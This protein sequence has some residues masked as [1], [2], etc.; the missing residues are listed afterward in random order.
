MIRTISIAC[1]L[2]NKTADALNRESGRI[3]TEVMIEHY[4]V[5]R[6]HNLWLSNP[7]MQKYHDRI[8]EA[9]FL[10]AHSIDAAQEAFYKACKTS[11]AN[12]ENGAKYPHKKKPYRTTIWKNT[13]MRKKGNQLLLSLARG[14][15]PITFRLPP[16]L[17]V[18]NGQQFLELRLVYDRAHRKYDWHIVIENGLEP[19]PTPG[20]NVA[21]VDLGEVHPAAITDGRDSLVISC[22]ELRSLN[23]YLNKRLAELKSLQ[24]GKQKHSG[25]WWRIQGRINRFLAQNKQQRRDLEHKISRAVVDW[26]VIHQVGTLAIG[27]VRDVADGKRLNRKSQQKV[28]NWSHGTVRRYIAYKA[29]AEGILVNDCV[30]ESYTTQTCVCCGRR[31]KPIGRIYACACGQTY[32]R[33]VGGAANILSRF[34][35]GALSKV[36][37]PAPL[38]FRPHQKVSQSVAL[39][40]LLDTEQVARE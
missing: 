35:Y 1:K 8:S 28:S 19:L 26:S 11:R 38:F 31:R 30:D 9:S 34:C 24:S 16:D 7:R 29:E 14:N 18:L 10:H 25:R 4:R 22:R 13:G 36:E 3:Y 33:D 20:S 32:D 21:G 37:A 12:R 40:S 6:H 5:Y 27:D 39:R 2:P 23:Q 17:A 15:Q